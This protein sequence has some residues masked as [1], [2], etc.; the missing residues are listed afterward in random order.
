MNINIENV[1]SQH[2][3]PEDRIEKQD[4]EELQSTIA[5]I[6]N[7]F[8]EESKDPALLVKNLRAWTKCHEQKEIVN[9]V[10]AV[11]KDIRDN[12]KPAAF[13][14]IGIVG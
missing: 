12:F 10:I 7:K 8:R 2:I 3:N 9:D 6:Q 4:I 13:V 11:A 1:S 14:T 5:G